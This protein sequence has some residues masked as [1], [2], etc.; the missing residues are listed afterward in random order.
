MVVV[1]ALISVASLL[2]AYFLGVFTGAHYMPTTPSRVARMLRLANL[3]KNDRLLD[4]GSGDGRIVIEAARMGVDAVG[5]EINPVL[6]LLS[7]RAIRKAGLSNARIVWGDFWKQDF[8]GYTI[9]TVYGIPHIMGLLERKVVAELPSQGRV[10]S[11]TF[12]FPTMEGI[13]EEG[14]YLYQKA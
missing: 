2:I 13:H 9:V 3:T 4:I 7:R 11:N 1:Y 14:I 6:V 10:V 5:Y 12:S 8:S